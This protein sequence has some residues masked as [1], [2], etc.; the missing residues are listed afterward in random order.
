M[1]R[2]CI[3]F[4]ECI[5]W[6]KSILSEFNRFPLITKWI[7][8][9]VN[10][11]YCWRSAT[12]RIDWKRRFHTLWRVLMS[13]YSSAHVSLEWYQVCLDY[14]I[15][16]KWMPA[17][18]RWKFIHSFLFFLSMFI[19]LPHCQPF[20]FSHSVFCCFCYLD[21]F[22]VWRK[23]SN[24]NHLQA[25]QKLMGL[26]ANISVHTN[27]ARRLLTTFVSIALAYIG[28]ML[29]KRFFIFPKVAH[30]PVPLC[31]SNDNAR[32]S[33]PQSTERWENTS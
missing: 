14:A 19:F 5:L 30:T 15:R 26:C 24:Y 20:H 22:F 3:H 18:I 28:M 31:H 2:L 27:G 8:N 11:A 32:Y 29:G 12:L 7:I 16:N 6:E 33:E 10:I 13:T 17:W 1:Q 25:D 21:R 4:G 23:I 9:W